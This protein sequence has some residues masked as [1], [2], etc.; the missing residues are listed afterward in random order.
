[1]EGF[2]FPLRVGETELVTLP[3]MDGNVLIQT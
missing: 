1:M 3:G 2:I